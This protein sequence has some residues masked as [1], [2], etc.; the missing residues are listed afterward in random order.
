MPKKFSIA[1]KR[2]WLDEY[3]SGKSEVHIA[4][5]NKCD[6]RTV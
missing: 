1:D 3:E 6:A 4:K 5:K 2:K